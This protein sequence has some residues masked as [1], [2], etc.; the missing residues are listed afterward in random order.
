LEGEGVTQY[1]KR[2]AAE[3]KQHSP[4]WKNVDV[5]GLY[6]AAFDVAETQIFAD[7][8]RE[9]R[10]PTNIP[11][12]EVVTRVTSDAVGR[13]ITRFFASHPG[14]VWDKFKPPF[15]YVKRWGDE[16]TG[17]PVF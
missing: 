5:A 15:R 16:K 1:R 9:A 12:G 13:P 8:E 3:L 17:V 11:K 2:L 7:A 14:A 4:A 6:G 10:H